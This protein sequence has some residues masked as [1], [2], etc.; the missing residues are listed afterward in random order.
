MLDS[1]LNLATTLIGFVASIGLIIFV[2]A[3][4]VCGRSE[5]VDLR[6]IPY[7]FEMHTQFRAQQNIPQPECIVDG[8]EPVVIAS[9]PTLKYIKQSPCVTED[10]CTICLGEYEERD[11]LRIMPTC[12]HNFHS[13]CIDIWLESHSTCPICR[14]SLNSI[15]SG[16]YMTNSRNTLS[17]NA[18][19]RHFVNQWEASNN[20]SHEIAELN[21]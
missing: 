19:F 13:S 9:M 12:G 5:S 16:N 14:V 7:E 8:L 11:I 2:C 15:F 4:L 10:Q 1:G 20:V 18:F 17:R 6:T 21:R 3:R